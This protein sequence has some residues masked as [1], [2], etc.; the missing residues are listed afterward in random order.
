VWLGALAGWVVL[1]AWS[2]IINMAILPDRYAAAQK[3]GLLLAQP[4]YGFFLPVY[5][6]A[7]FLVSCVLAWVYAGVRATY[8]PGPGTALKVGLLLGFMA[9]FPMAFSQAAWGPLSRFFPLWWML[10]LWVGSILSAYVSAWVYR[11]A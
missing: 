1:M 2:A 3:A 6:I 8:G 11:E 10:E 7:L 5:F 9:G 4:R